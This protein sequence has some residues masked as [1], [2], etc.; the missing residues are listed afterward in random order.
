MKF[1]TSM[2]KSILCFSSDSYILVKRTVTI[3][4]EGADDA[5]K[6]TDEINKRVIFKNCTPFSDCISK[7]NNTQTDNAKDIDVTM[8]MYKLIEYS[9]N[10]SKTSRS[11]W[12][13]YR[14]EPAAAIVNSESFRFKTEITGKI[15]PADRTKD[16]EIEVPLKYLSNF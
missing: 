4:G 11:L 2:L 1:E 7:I 14:Y 12:Q 16:L 10:Y 13:Y 5:G 8:P 9:N 15:P 3:T 6:W